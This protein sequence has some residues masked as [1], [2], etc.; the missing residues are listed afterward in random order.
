[1]RRFLYYLPGA[2]AITPAILSKLQ[3]RDRFSDGGNLIANCAIPIEEG[4]DGKS[5]LVLAAGMQPPTYAPDRQTWI[6]SENGVWVA[7][8]DPEAAPGPNDLQRIKQLPGYPATL[9]ESEWTVPLLL[10]WDPTTTQQ[11][12]TLPQKLMPVRDGGNYR[13]E[14]RVHPQHAPLDLL[15]RRLWE[16]FCEDFDKGKVITMDAACADVA[17]LLNINYRIGAAEIGLLGL[18]DESSA[19]QVLGFAI[20]TP[21]WQKQAIDVHRGEF[22]LVEPDADAAI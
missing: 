14:K 19:A 9:G 12:S 4:P 8:E 20:D 10:R 2:S 21:G 1:M 7:I 6:E 11:I 5:G 13:W 15:A 22:Q 18:L 17:Q 3:L 16:S